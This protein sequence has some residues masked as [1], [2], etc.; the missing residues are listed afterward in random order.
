MSNPE[1]KLSAVVH[2]QAELRECIEQARRLTDESD[3]L[4]QR[5]RAD[6]DQ[7]EDEAVA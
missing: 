1:D 2:A 5:C 3:A 7:D 4:V 6:N